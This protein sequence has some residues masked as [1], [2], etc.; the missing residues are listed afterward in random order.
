MLDSR[1]LHHGH[2]LKCGQRSWRTKTGTSIMRKKLYF[3]CDEV[4]PR[5]SGIYRFLARMTLLKPPATM[6]SKA[7]KMCFSMSADSENLGTAA[8]GTGTTDCNG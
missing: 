8:D 6:C 4:S 3:H 7:F 5:A 1:L 2:V